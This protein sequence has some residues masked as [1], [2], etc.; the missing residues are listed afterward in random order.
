M[1][2]QRDR[3]HPLECP[4]I[5]AAE[6][7]ARQHASV[8]LAH[9][10]ELLEDYVELIADL[11][12][13]GGE[14]RAVDLAHRFGVAQPTVTKMLR[15]LTDH[16]LIVREPYRAI[17]LTE[18]GRSLAESSRQR[19][20]LVLSFLRALG[21]SE[22]TARDDAEGIEHHVSAETLEAMRRFLGHGP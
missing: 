20:A 4:A 15:R 5:P 1:T 13:A 9:E 21:V 10:T 11:I 8:R 19:H 22:D 3:A 12:D 16:G 18:A 6:Q 17:H 7:Q 14:A 2:S